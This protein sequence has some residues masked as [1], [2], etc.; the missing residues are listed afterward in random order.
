MAPAH[1]LNSKFD[2]I[3]EMTNAAVEKTAAAFSL[4]AMLFRL[5]L[6]DC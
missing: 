6:P 4:L 2:S 1:N 3:V 5:A